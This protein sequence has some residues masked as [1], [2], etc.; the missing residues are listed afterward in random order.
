MP[1]RLSSPIRR[2]GVLSGGSDVPGIN[3]AIKALVYRAR[4][5]DMSVLG[6]RGGWEGLTFL[7]RSLGRD[8]LIFRFDEPE[9]WQQGYIMPLT[10][11]STRTIDRLGGT[12]LQ[13]THTNPANIKVGN[14][15]PHSPLMGKDASRKSA[16]I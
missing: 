1:A 3:A 8:R 4:D 9:T 6:I 13:S 10:R 12:I 5:N 11:L 2:L 16:W 14:L 7:D 15:P